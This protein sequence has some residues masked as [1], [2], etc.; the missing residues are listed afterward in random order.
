MPTV[1][2]VGDK[3]PPIQSAAKTIGNLITL[4]LGAG[5]VTLV[6]AF[7]P[8]DYDQIVLAVGAFLTGLAQLLVTFGTSNKATAPLIVNP[9]P[10]APT[11]PVL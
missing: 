1:V 4:I 3:L 6:V 8:E 11:N 9:G 7:T 5:L 10:T 2:A